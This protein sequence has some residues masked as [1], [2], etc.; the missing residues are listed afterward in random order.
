M[1]KFLI[2]MILL[3]LA[4]SLP[5]YAQNFEVK[6]VQISLEEAVL[7]DRATGQQWVVQVGDEVEG[8]K[9]VKITQDYV[10]ISKPREGLPT[11]MTEIPVDK[12]KRII[13]VSPK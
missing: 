11:L 10:T 8:W 13:H 2:V 1:G 4:V 3:S 9:I 5:G 7:A 12:G 6:E